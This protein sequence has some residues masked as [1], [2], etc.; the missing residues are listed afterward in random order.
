MKS[1][2]ESGGKKFC[3]NRCYETT[4][5][6]CVICNKLLNEWI[7]SEGKKYCSERCFSASWPSC[8]VCSK[9][10][11]QWTEGEDGGIYCSTQCFEKMLPNCTCCGQKMQQ[12]TENDRGMFCSEACLKTSYP[13]CSV[14]HTRQKE[15]LQ[16]EDGEIYC[17]EQCFAK[18]LPM[19]QTCHKSMSEWL[20]SDGKTY[21]SDTCIEA[22]AP[23][24]ECCGKRQM[25]WITVDGRNY[26]SDA[27]Y[28]KTWPTCHVCNETMNKWYIH[29][30]YQY[31][32][33]MCIEKTMP[34]CLHCQK[35]LYEWIELTD[36]RR[37]CSEHCAD[38]SN[39]KINEVLLLSEVTG[40]YPDEIQVIAAHEN[41]STEQFA[42]N[43]DVLLNALEKQ[44]PL[45]EGMTA[46]FENAGVF[47]RLATNLTSYN[48][49]RGGTNGFKGFVFEE[50]HAANATA[51]GLATDVIANNGI[52]D[53]MILNPDGTRTLGQAKLGY[54]TTKIDWSAYKDQK[55]II[56]RGNEK[57]LQSARE[58]GLDVIESN[59]SNKQVSSVAKL[60]QSE[61]R[62]RG[63]VNAPI[64]SRM[65]SI[66]Q[67]GAIS[68]KRGGIF[69]AGF[70]LG[71]NAVDLLYGDKTI[72]EAATGVAKDTAVA[73]ATSYVV[74]ALASTQAGVTISGAVGG[75][76]TAAGSLVGKTVIGGAIASGSSA[77]TGAIAATSLG[78]AVSSGA[79]TIATSAVGTAIATSAIGSVVIAAAPVLAVGAAVGG[80]FKLGKKLFG[81]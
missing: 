74:G 26:C 27:C 81:R 72:G 2:T 36:G 65:V 8:T 25:Q 34:T 4:L 61:S 6:G 15:W 37:Y 63:I 29:E 13:A 41:W 17:S 19:C 7:E 66:H 68:A 39:H 28:E 71:G 9:K 24:C 22:T 59:F 62:L 49:M 11:K 50:L 3:S 33:H 58:A 79:V 53:F 76:M 46:A 52:A 73:T 23:P 40:L 80:V 18:M 67:A 47:N 5:E 10:V 56:D 38:S 70:S 31:C 45:T 12:W 1:W 16:T 57:L 77:V 55:I 14:C 35:P 42:E 30:G 60:L 54:N 69:G 43:I 20:V 21:C 78:T 64:T 75:A 44:I 48:T 51:N 32:S